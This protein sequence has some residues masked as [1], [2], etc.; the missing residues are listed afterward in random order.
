MRLGL[1]ARN[2][3]TRAYHS[4]SRTSF[5]SYLKRS[6]IQHTAFGTSFEIVRMTYQAFRASTLRNHL[7]EHP[8]GKS[9][10]LVFSFA[11]GG[12]VGP[13][14]KP[15]RWSN[16]PDGTLDEGLHKNAAEFREAFERTI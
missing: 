10:V 5:A 7:V 4:G 9:G 13:Q 6:I 11:A 15:L 1:I 12:P 2:T 8:D 3:S 16:D 14:M